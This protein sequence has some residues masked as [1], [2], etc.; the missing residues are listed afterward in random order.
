M[1]FAATDNLNFESAK[2]RKQQFWG[3]CQSVSKNLMHLL[4]KNIIWRFKT[5]LT[6][7]SII[8]S[9]KGHEGFMK[10]IC[11]LSEQWIDRKL[12]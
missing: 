7:K 6:L 2:K 10:A 4:L 12:Q 11:R 8:S 1:L 5:I 9:I 3:K